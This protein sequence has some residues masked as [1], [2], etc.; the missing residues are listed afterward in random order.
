MDV[1]KVEKEIESIRM[2]CVGLGN[3]VWDLKESSGIDMRQEV[4]NY[5]AEKF[6][7]E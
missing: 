3:A 6:E 7:G 2:S 5:F 1:K 4:I